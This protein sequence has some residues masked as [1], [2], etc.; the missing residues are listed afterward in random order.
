[1][2]LAW[3][4]YPGNREKI[5]GNRSAGRPGGEGAGGMVMLP[6]GRDDPRKYIRLAALLREQVMDGA[7]KPGNPPPSITTLSQQYGY[8]R[9]TC[10]KALRL[11]EGE[12]LLV[13]IPGLGYYVVD[14]KPSR[15]ETGSS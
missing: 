8:A 14:P 15:Q 4:L 10:A 2:R 1:M 7:L 6:G 9:Q 12:G 11:L 3:P 5:H 13:R